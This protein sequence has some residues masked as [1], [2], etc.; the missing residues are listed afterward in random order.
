M[1][2]AA[3]QIFVAPT[4]NEHLLHVCKIVVDFRDFTAFW[5]LINTNHYLETNSLS[6]IN[7]H[8]GTIRRITW[9]QVNR[10]H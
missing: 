3:Q 10:W 8:P 7:R 5:Y 1:E 9:Q 2:L 4:A 6:H